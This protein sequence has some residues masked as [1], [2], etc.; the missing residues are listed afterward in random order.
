MLSILESCTSV[1]LSVTLLYFAGVQRALG[2]SKD[3]SGRNMSPCVGPVLYVGLQTRV[4]VTQMIGDLKN[5]MEVN[6]SAI[7]GTPCHGNYF[8]SSSLS[9]A[10]QLYYKYRFC[11]IFDDHNRFSYEVN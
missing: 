1:C 11:V 10:S 7:G 2:S 3:P 9:S 8:V 4:G 6:S 5:W